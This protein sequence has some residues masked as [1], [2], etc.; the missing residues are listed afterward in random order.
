MET[1]VFADDGSSPA[2]TSRGKDSEFRGCSE[3]ASVR[4]AT[5]KG[6]EVEK[7]LRA[8]GRV[9]EPWSTF[10]RLWIRALEEHRKTQSGSGWFCSALDS[11]DTAR[12][13]TETH[14]VPNSDSHPHEGARW[15]KS[16]DRTRI[17]TRRVHC[18]QTRQHCHGDTVSHQPSTS[19]KTKNFSLCRYDTSLFYQQILGLK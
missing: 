9:V 7:R 16:A 8:V 15:W 2:S 1:T 10:A 14:P 3:K 19:L 18:T 17:A 4:R 11:A 5:A 13:A 6:L 12:K